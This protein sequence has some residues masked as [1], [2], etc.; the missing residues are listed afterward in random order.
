MRLAGKSAIVTGGAGGI[1]YGIATAFCKQGANVLIVDIN[2]DAVERAERELAE[3][4]KVV[5]LTK[6][7]G[8]P[9]APDEIRD[10]AVREFGGVDVLVNNAHASKQAPLAEHTQELFDLSF[11]TGFYPT[12]R[13]MQACYEQLKQRRGSV[14]NFASGAGLSG[15]P[16]QASYAAAKE[17]IRGVSR[18]AANEWGRDGINVNMISPIAH[19]AGV[20][21]W[22]QTHAEQYQQMI[23]GIPLGHMGD[24]E[25]EI[26]PIAV[27]LASDD[28]DYMTGQTL[29]ADGGTQM[30]R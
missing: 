2:P 15:Q 26:A 12:V 9:A 27:F 17:A 28:S 29:M 8:D 22:A 3:H 7:I 18:V 16:N 30:L 11:N 4:G 21:T 24:P 25:N 6:D 10:T 20:D 5:G 23:K 1:G 14:I 13:L 19:T